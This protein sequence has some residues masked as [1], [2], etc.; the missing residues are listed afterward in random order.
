MGWIFEPDR[1]IYTQIVETIQKRILAGVYPA[2]SN[3]P[4]V[5]TLALEAGV[6]PNTMQ[7]AL[8]DLEGS[9]L[10]HTNRTTGRMVTDDIELI[11]YFK[12]ELATYYV[13][14]YFD[15]MLSFGLDRD[16]AIE[17]FWTHAQS[18]PND[19]LFASE[20]QAPDETQPASPQP[21]PTQPTSP[22][23][24]PTQP[25]SPQPAPIQLTPTH[26]TS[27]QPAPTQP[28]LSNPQPTSNGEYNANII[29]TTDENG[30]S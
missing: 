15:G 5:R 13:R 16:S 28:T 17:I 9:G 24:T 26:P 14:Q 11:N 12:Q 8:A 19:S 1:P 30:G 10:I 6:N 2:G 7:R 22:Q 18:S 21:A 27:P 29:A 25:T 3:V 20:A 23:L 4:S